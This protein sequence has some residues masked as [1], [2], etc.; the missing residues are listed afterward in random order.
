MLFTEKQKMLTALFETIFYGESLAKSGNSAD[1]QSRISL[2]I[3]YIRNV[4][5]APSA[6][7]A[8]TFTIYDRRFALCRT[9]NVRAMKLFSGSSGPKAV[10]GEHI[11]GRNTSQKAQE[12]FQPISSLALPDS[13][14]PA[15]YSSDEGLTKK[16]VFPKNILPAGSVSRVKFVF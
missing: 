1:I 4:F 8:H 7:P 15:L 16:S 6:F 13:S 10:G 9:A 5:V 3:S 14:I 2:G 11:V 12:G